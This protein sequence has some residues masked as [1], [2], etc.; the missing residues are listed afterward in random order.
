LYKP[1]RERGNSS[2]LFPLPPVYPFLSIDED[3][4]GET[5]KDASTEEN[6]ERSEDDEPG[7]H[8]EVIHLLL[9]IVGDETQEGTESYRER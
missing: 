4:L 5:A 2:L 3:V 1:G 9:E 7:E 8:W 6:I